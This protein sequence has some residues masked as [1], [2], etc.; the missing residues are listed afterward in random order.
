MVLF[1]L[2][3]RIQLSTIKFWY[4]ILKGKLEAVANDKET[5][6]MVDCLKAILHDE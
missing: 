3:V 5:V 6:I 2:L 4:H 1:T